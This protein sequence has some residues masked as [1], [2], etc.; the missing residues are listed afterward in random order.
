MLFCHYYAD[1]LLFATLRHYFIS[2][3]A[4]RADFS[5]SFAPWRSA[6]HAADFAAFITL[7]QR[8]DVFFLSIMRQ[9]RVMILFF[10]TMPPFRCAF[11]LFPMLSRR[12]FPRCLSPRSPARWRF[13]LIFAI[14]MSDVAAHAF[15]DI[16]LLAM[17]L[18]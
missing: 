6:H 18:R 10:I 14:L 16:A 13:R 5:F 3:Y 8:S 9:C 2:L 11:R 7:R 12:R 17:P 1:A 15:F 4:M